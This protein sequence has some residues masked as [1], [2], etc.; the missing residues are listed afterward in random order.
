MIC[1]QKAR[2]LTYFGKNYLPT[3]IPLV[4]AYFSWIAPDP[5]LPLA[6]QL[7]TALDSLKVQSQGARELK[8]KLDE[9]HRVTDEAQRKLRESEAMVLAKV[10]TYRKKPVESKV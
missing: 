2:L 7:E 5:D 6:V 8:Q 10:R 4:T 9:L 3:L 1:C